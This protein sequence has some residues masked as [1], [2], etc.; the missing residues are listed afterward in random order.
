MLR[1]TSKKLVARTEFTPN[2]LLLL[3]PSEQFPPG[4]FSKT[5]IY[6]KRDGDIQYLADVFGTR[7]T[8][9]YLPLLQKKQKWLKPERNVQIGEL[10]IVI[11]ST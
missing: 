9:E 5:D 6:V 7:W 4:T 2:H 3:K 11:E 10:V 1:G 8:T